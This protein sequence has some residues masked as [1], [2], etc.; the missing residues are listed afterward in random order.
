MPVSAAPQH[1]TDALA[2]SWPPATVEAVFSATA[3]FTTTFVALRGPFATSIQLRL[4][5]NGL[6]TRVDVL[7]FPPISAPFGSGV[8][9][10]AKVGGGSGGYLRGSVTL[11]IALRFDRR[12]G[13]G[14]ILELTLTTAAPGSPVDAK[15]NAALAGLGVFRDGLLD[16]TAGT[17]IVSGTISPVP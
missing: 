5:F 4:L 11:P 7:D 6:R 13:E 16:G 15:G 2:P 14:S 10:I 12:G 9:T 1:I 3:S 8:V 17:V